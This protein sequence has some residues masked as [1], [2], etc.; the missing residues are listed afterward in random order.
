MLFTL[1]PLAITGANIDIGAADGKGEVKVTI[2]GSTDEV[3]E[4]SEI[5]RKLLRDRYPS[6]FTV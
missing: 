3:R 5:I 4:A 2:V 1:V 6:A